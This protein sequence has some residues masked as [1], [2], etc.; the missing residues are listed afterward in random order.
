MV[1]N[2]S[3]WRMEWASEIRDRVQ[4]LSNVWFAGKLENSWLEI[5]RICDFSAPGTNLFVC[6]CVWIEVMSVLYNV[7]M[8]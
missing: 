3:Y 1:G 7:F 2:G 8:V 4:S 5:V 6:K